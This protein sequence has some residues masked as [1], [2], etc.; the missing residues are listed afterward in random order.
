MD[1]NAKN[2]QK[3][4]ADHIQAYI[5]KIIYH[6][7][8]GFIP[9]MQDFFKICKSINVIHHMKKLKHNT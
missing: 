6:D 8:L 4:L 5:K 1:I 3:I 9:E 2:P 7:Q